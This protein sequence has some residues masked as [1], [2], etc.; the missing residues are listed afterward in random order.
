MTGVAL[1][2]PERYVFTRARLRLRP[3]G[4]PAVL[5]TLWPLNRQIQTLWRTPGGVPVW[6]RGNE[7]ESRA[8]ESAG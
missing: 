4:F 1:A 5:L 2:F 7:G 6:F 8:A 3:L